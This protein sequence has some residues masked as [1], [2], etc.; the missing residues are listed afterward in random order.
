MSN[1]NTFRRARLSILIGMALAA[2]PALVRA[3]VSL[4]TV[5]DLAQRNSSEVKL[6]EADVLKAEAAF[7]ESKDVIIPSVLLST[8]LP[9]FPEVGFTGTPPSIW[10]ATVQ[11]L[12]FGV[13]QKRYIDAARFG[14]QAAS[15]N[16]RDAREQVAL[17]ASTAY[18][19]LDTINS[20]LDAAHEQEGYASRLVAIE[21][22]RAEAGVDPLS[23]LLQA[24]LTAAQIK[25]KRLQLEA[26]AGTLATQLASLTGLPV[27]SIMPVHAS[28]PEIP[29]VNGNGPSRSRAGIG[30]AQ[31]LARS[32]QQLAMGD[33]EI[34][35]LPQMSFIAQ[36][37]RNTTLL[38]SVNSYFSRPL[39]ANNFSSGISIQVP[40]FDMW[41]RAK[42]RETAADALRAKV[43]AEQAERQS[44]VQIASLTG[45]LRELDA[46][47]EVASLKQQIAGEQLKTVL[48]Q[49]ELGNGAGTG[50][51]APPQLSP[52]AEQLARID[53]RQKLEDA[54]DAGFDLDKARL[55]LLRA[56]GHMEDWLHELHNR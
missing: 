31:L 53:E 28:I 10:T 46:L 47:A 2:S 6:A 8:G 56:L 13:P 33:K 35:Y 20:E 7:S 27:E 1:R 22:E 34:N 51:E 19:E 17:D 32:K 18:I 30:A 55:S 3:Q 49:L 45:S 54:L 29:K 5:V 41:H 12:V 15:S 39:P 23:E 38:N 14:L 50:P 21:Q 42:A 11:S 52:K 36:Y 16:L 37:N 9:T 43:E 25:L 24:R 4:T 40:L 48:T 26:R 44:D